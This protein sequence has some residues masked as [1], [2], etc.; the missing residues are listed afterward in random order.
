MALRE[1]EPPKPTDESTEAKR[2]HYAKWERLNRL[3]L[4]S[5]KR[6]IAEH[7][8][9]GITENNNA[10]EFLVV[11]E[12]KHQISDN[13]EAGNFMDELMNM[14]YNDMTGVRDYILEMVHL[15]TKLKAHD[16]PIP[17][18]FIVYQALNPLPFSFSQIKTAYNTLNQTSSVNDLITKCVVEEEKLKKENNESTHLVALGKS[19]NQK[20]VQN[21]RKP[22]FHSHK[23]SKNIKKS[24]SEKPKNGNGN[25]N[26][27]NIDLKS[28]NCNKKGHKRVNCFKFKTWLEKKKNEHGMLSAH[29]CFESN[30]VNVPLYSWCLDS[31]ATV[32]VA[33]SLQGIRNHG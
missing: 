30:L 15:Q 6:S 17:D 26:A 10:K 33:T 31:G 4:I 28:Y 2:A 21:S 13:A 19:N 12:K 32:D 14:R 29:V 3:S 25:G 23:K 27:K 24:G 20:R 22:N 9:G 7:L 5:I 11:V 18:K 8:L 16:I 1:D